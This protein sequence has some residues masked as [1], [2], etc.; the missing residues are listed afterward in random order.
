MAAYVR[1]Y[2]NSTDL[3]GVLYFFK[4]LGNLT[5]RDSQIIHIVLN[6]WQF[7]FISKL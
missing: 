6:T 7:I 3:A 5:R 2:L 4:Q 1:F